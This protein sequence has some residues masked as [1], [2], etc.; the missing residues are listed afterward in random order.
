MPEREVGPPEGFASPLRLLRV[1][2]ERKLLVLAAIIIAVGVS[3]VASTT[4]QKMYTATS[5]L[6]LRDPGFAKA[7]FGADLFEP[8]TDPEREASTNIAVIKS[9]AVGGRVARRLRE[10]YPPEQISWDLEVSS[11]DNSDVVTIDATTADPQRSADVANAFATEYVVY[12]RDLNRDKIRDAQALVQTNLDALPPENVGERQG[13]EDSL[14]QLKVLE[15]LQTG[16]ADVV[17]RAQ[18]PDDPSSPQPLRN[19]ILAGLLGLLLGVGIALLADFIDRR[20]KTSEDVEQAFGYPVLVSVPRGAV[21][22]T[23]GEALVGPQAEPYRM[24]REGLRFLEISGEQRVILVTSPDA[25][26]GKT[27]VAVN[28]ARALYAGGDSVILIEA[29]LRRPTAARRLGLELVGQGLSSGLVVGSSLEDLLIPASQDGRLRVL[30]TGPMPPNP[31]DLLR[32]PNMAR[33][34]EEAR[35]AADVVVVDAPPLLPVS[36]TRVLL[37]MPGIDGVLIV[38]R[39]NTTRR[40]R[41]RAASRVLTQSDKRVLGVVVTGTRERLGDYYY[42]YGGESR[43]APTDFDGDGGVSTSVHPTTFR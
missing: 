43:G 39:A 12:Q 21:P 16:N 4:A 38:A 41:A 17:A 23:E 42:Y 36:D 10:D 11:N 22:K 34:L 2:W 29:D 40:D 18:A 14:K 19:G 26:E 33:L 9:P 13:L 3:I 32:T 6:L 27:T 25:G 5:E 30:P 28:L 8:G 31:A 35:Q 1:V 37:D 24:L 20:L 15:A 7:F